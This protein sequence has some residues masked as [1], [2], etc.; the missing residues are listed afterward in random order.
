MKRRKENPRGA[1]SAT[2]DRAAFPDGNWQTEPI[3]LEALGR[4]IRS[5]FELQDEQQVPWPM[6]DSPPE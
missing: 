6:E 3:D 4:K 1:E 5:A 2:A